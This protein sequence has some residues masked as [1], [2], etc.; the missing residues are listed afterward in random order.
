MLASGFFA[1]NG[2]GDLIKASSDSLHNY[3][4]DAFFEFVKAIA[5]LFH[6]RQQSSPANA[7]I[8]RCRA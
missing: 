3:P 8:Q 5:D 7:L 1:K 6:R 2:P 4:C